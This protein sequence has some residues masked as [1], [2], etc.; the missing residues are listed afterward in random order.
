[1]RLRDELDGL[2]RDQLR[3][4]YRRRDGDKP[5]DDAESAFAA[6]GGFATLSELIGRS[7]SMNTVDRNARLLR[8]LSLKRRFI[9]QLQHLTDEAY[10]TTDDFTA[11]VEKAGDRVL[12]LS[13][14]AD[15][16][17]ATIHPMPN[18]VD[19][20]LS[21]SPKSKLPAVPQEDNGLRRPG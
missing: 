16:G 14:S 5:D 4:L 6:V 9:Y 17:E 8:D 10:Q 3:A 18:V 7:G 13:K 12:K 19:Q 20:T 2:S 21:A 15:A 1:M 11:L